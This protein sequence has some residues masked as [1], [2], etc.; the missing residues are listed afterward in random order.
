VAVVL[1]KTLARFGGRGGGRPNLA[2]GGG[3]TGSP[4]AILD[5]AKLEIFSESV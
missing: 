4:D 2:Q 5:F 3:F 1:K